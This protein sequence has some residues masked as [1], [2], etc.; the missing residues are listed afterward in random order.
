MNAF[1]TANRDGFQLMDVTTA[2]LLMKRRGVKR[3]SCQEGSNSSEGNKHEF[4]PTVAETSESS[5]P[6][7]PKTLAILP[8]G[9]NPN[10]DTP[11][12]ETLESD[13]I[14]NN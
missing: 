4:L 14:N 1:Y 6:S 8:N 13:T 11:D 10:C 3:R 9:N 2:P 12:E 7:R 5:A